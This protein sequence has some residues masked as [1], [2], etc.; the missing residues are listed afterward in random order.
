MRYAFVEAG[1][2]EIRRAEG[3]ETTTFLATAAET[4]GRVSIF[5]S[6]L[7]RGNGAPWHFHDIDDEIFYIISGRVEFGVADE[8]VIAGPGDLVIAGPR[9][10]R[11]FRALEDSRLLVLNAPAGPSEGFLRDV[12]SLSGAPT[13]EDERRFAEQYGIHLGR[14]DDRAAR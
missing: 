5:D 2:A 10:A 6:A 9:V 3:G 7:P 14:P 4:G 1:R 12:M 13:A 11:R 8:V